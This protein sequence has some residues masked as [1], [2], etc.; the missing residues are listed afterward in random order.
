[1]DDYLKI[2]KKAWDKRT[3]VHIQSAFYDV[4][5]FLKG[6]NSLPAVDTLL[7]GDVRGKAILH[8]QCHFGM[9][10]ISLARMGAKV[11]AIDFSEKAIE[12]AK[13]LNRQLGTDVEFV[14][15]DVYDTPRY[16]GRQFDVVYTS[17]GVISWLPD[18][19]RWAKVVSGLLKPE[20]RFI[21]VEF[22]PILWM[23][24][25]TFEK[26]LYPYAQSQA[27]MMEE[28]TYT[29]NGTEAVDTTVTWNHGLAEVFQALKSNELTIHQF[30]ELP[31]SPFNLFANMVE[32]SEGLFQIAG[33]EGLF[34]LIFAIEGLK[35][36][37]VG[38]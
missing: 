27:F 8:L 4:D 24:D 21:M 36:E 6:D 32:T 29:D 20:G 25:E 7:L 3:E 19:M 37:A 33:K 31:G 34:P 14:C 15:C 30:L 9:D 1:M 12:K 23:F 11:T 13:E 16:V 38:E 10:L 26:V 2:N 35:R 18:L 22:H 28:K 5:S 17:Y